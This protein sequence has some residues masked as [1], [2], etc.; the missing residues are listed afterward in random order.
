M[1]AQQVW[2]P[3]FVSTWTF[4]FFFLSVSTGLGPTKLGLESRVFVAL[5]GE[6]LDI[7][8]ELHLPAKQSKDVLRCFDPHHKEIYSCETPETGNQSHYSNLTLELK[9]LETSGVYSCKYKTEMVYWFLRVGG[10]GYHEPATWEYTVLGS[11]NVMLLVFSVVGSVFVFRG[12]GKESI[13]EGGD[14]GRKR[15]QNRNKMEREREEDGIDSITATSTSFYASL[16]TRPRSIYDVLD[17]SAAN[18]VP[19]QSKAKAKKTM[20]QTKQDQN[21]GIFE[22]VYENF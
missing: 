13:A 2:R 11:F 22:S 19:G 21:E 10:A 18:K 7:N 3:L 14:T 15:K 6:H 12:H 17:H 5:K 8:C 20:E 4:V 9:N 1:E 16:E